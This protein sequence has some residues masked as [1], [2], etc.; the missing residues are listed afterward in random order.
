LFFRGLCWDPS[1][2]HQQSSFF[3]T[4]P[5][6]H[7][8]ICF[9]G[10]STPLSKN[11]LA[12]LDRTYTFLFLVSLIL[13]LF[14]GRLSPPWQPWGFFFDFSAEHEVVF[15][16]FPPPRFFS[17]DLSW[18]RHPHWRSPPPTPNPRRRL[19]V[20][21]PFPPVCVPPAVFLRLPANC[22]FSLFFPPCRRGSVHV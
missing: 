13:Y 14:F 7:L 6:R 8:P 21:R 11:S 15:F 20:E 1:T 10:S 12:F 16:F 22:A 2:R 18:R 17:K 19:P 3:R 5:P 4:P 9:D